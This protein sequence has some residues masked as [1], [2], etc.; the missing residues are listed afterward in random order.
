MNVVGFEI[1]QDVVDQALLSFDTDRAFKKSD[2]RKEL[3]R[4]GVPNDR[5]HTADR[6]ADRILQRARKAGTH[7]Y[8]SGMWRRLKS[9]SAS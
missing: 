7:A 1:S 3:V 9:M 2:L 5:F 8:S 6:C 4:L